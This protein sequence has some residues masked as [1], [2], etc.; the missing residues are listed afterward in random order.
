M[1]GVAGVGLLV[2]ADLLADEHITSPPQVQPDHA[3]YQYT[4]WIRALH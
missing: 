2:L 1:L 4:P 3:L